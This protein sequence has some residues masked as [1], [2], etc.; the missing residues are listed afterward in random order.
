MG[1]TIRHYNRNSNLVKNS[2]IQ[3]DLVEI[4]PD[5]NSITHWLSVSDACKYLS[6]SKA[7]LYN[8]MQ[9]G[10]LSF[11]Y[12][13]GTRQRR[14]KKSDLDALLMPGNPEDAEDE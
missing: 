5:C 10:R 4:M 7:T 11:Y 1:F 6:V 8:Y 2:L 9:D 13:A 12:L 14:V 3:S